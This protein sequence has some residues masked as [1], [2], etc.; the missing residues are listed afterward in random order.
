MHLGENVRILR[1][2][3]NLS[4]EELAAKIGRTK[5][6]VS[7]IENTGKGSY[8]TIEAIA[9]VFKLTVDQLKEFEGRPQ[10]LIKE[11]EVMASTYEANVKELEKQIQKLTNENELLKQSLMAHQSLIKELKTK[12]SKKK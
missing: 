4:Q 3:S 7:Q 10:K 1:A 8:Y 2:I 9:K 11:Y 6:L 12:K 5:A